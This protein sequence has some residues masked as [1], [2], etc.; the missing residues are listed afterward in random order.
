MTSIGLDMQGYDANDWDLT[1]IDAID[2]ATSVAYV[3]GLF[4]RVAPSS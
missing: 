3:R 4:D 1:E 2:S